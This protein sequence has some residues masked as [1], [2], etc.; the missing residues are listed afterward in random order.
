MRNTN[1]V[2]CK[3]TVS[4]P[5]AVMSTKK[6]KCAGKGTKGNTWLNFSPVRTKFL[7]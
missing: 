3:F 5:T 2:I 1:F 7:E 4:N 6:K